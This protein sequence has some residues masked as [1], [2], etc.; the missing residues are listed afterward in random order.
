MGGM[1]R[2]DASAK[3]AAAAPKNSNRALLAI[4][5]TVAIVAAVVVAVSIGTSTART[6]S[7]AP[8]APAGATAKGGPMVLNPDAPAG[9]PVVD[10]YEDPQ[11]PVCQQFESIYGPTVADLVK[12]N[13]AKVR[14]FTLSFLDKGLKNDSSLRAANGAMCAADQGKF[15]DY[16]TATFVGQ[17]AQEGQGWTSAE[18]EGFASR[19]GVPDLAA[20]KSCQNALT[21]QGHVEA[22]QVNATKDGVTGTPTVKVNGKSVKLTGNAQDLVSA[23]G[24]A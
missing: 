18:L 17:P 4:L 19:A 15:K 8:G 23:V 11:C 22:L 14:V 1:P 24:A 21:Y 6:T 3:I 12:N 10:I 16:V 20:W 2:P 9:A 13:K 5:I 7:T